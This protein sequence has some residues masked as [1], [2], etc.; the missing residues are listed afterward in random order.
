MEKEK[1]IFDLEMML[2]KSKDEFE[3]FK[4]KNEMD[5]MEQDNVKRIAELEHERLKREHELTMQ[6]A[7]EKSEFLKAQRETEFI[8][9]KEESE[10]QR[11]T[12]EK[13]LADIAINELKI[14]E[15]NDAKRREFE[16]LMR[17][18]Q[19]LEAENDRLHKLEMNNINLKS[20]NIANNSKTSDS[21][22]KLVLAVLAAIPFI[23]KF[24][25]KEK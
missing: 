9:L 2:K 24:C 1:S 16:T 10:V 22:F 11:R 21:Y 3:R 7:K 19:L 18:K 6:T 13:L 17:D 15:E 4:I 14:K 23:W 5:K 12:Q 25:Q 20:A 8:K